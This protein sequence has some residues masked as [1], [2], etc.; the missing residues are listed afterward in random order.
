MGIEN[1]CEPNL[2]KYYPVPNDNE[3]SDLSDITLKNISVA[4]LLL[5][6]IAFMVNALM[7]YLF[8]TQEWVII[9]PAISMVNIGVTLICVGGV[10][11]LIN[12]LLKRNS[13]AYDH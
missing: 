11:Y 1:E 3:A 8:M 13:R 12:F 7:V 4:L 2:A 9:G 10:L 6:F 5:G